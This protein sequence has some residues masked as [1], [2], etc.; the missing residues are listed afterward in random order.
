V[1]YIP[2]FSRLTKIYRNRTD[3][4]ED[5]L[6]R[7]GTFLDNLFHHL[8]ERSIMNIVKREN[9]KGEKIDMHRN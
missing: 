7:I 2:A 6:L 4:I 5:Y 3:W 8:S 9:R 1:S